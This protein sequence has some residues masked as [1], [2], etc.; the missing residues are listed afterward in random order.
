MTQALIRCPMCATEFDPS[1][2]SACQSCP[3][4]SGCQMT[5][6]PHCGYT[7]VDPGQS[8]LARWASGLFNGRRRKGRRGRR[9]RHGRA[10]GGLT[11]ADAEV[12]DT[13]EIVTLIG[14]PLGKRQHLQAYGVSPGTQV[15]ILQQSP[16]TIL[17]SENTE[18]ALERWL[19]RGILV[20]S[21]SE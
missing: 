6:C 1:G 16:L 12:G 3:L 2:R 17:R 21:R 4:N 8:R 18:L 7:T 9:R 13:V 5:C 10:A 15:E 19:A 20:R 11:L 14:L